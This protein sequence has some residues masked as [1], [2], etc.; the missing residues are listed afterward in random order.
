M[1]NKIL[2][3]AVV[4]IL[5]VSGV[6]IYFLTD[7]N[8]G[9]GGKLPTAGQEVTDAKGRTVIVPDNLDNGIITVGSSG[10]LRFL[11]C[12]DVYDKIIEV[13]KG[14]VTDLKHGRAYSYAF[15][16]TGFTSDQYHPDGVMESDTAEKIGRKNPS[17][18]VIQE[19]VWNKYT[20][21][22]Q[23]LADHFTTVVISDQKMDEMWTSEYK[24]APWMVDTFELLGTVLGQ[25]D[26]AQEI[27][28][29]IETILADIRSHVG[30]SVNTKT[31]VAGVT[32]QG[33]NPLTNTFPVY[34]PLTLAG[35]T[36]AY[37]KSTTDIKVALTEEDVAQLD[38]DHI[39]IDPSSS[40]KLSEN[41]SQLVMKY[42]YEVNNDSDPD[43]DIKLYVTMPLVWDNINYDCALVSAYYIAHLL[44]GTLTVEEVKSK[45]IDVF[46]LF[47]GD[48]GKNVLSDMTA[49]FE[50]KSAT[51]NVELPL[52]KEVKIVLTGSKYYTAEV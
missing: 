32:Y 47:Y 28:A 43:N 21:I 51:Y 12:F 35:G 7:G 27:I 26:R 37:T 39:L 46:T 4:A 1:N 11:S 29:G 9:G 6:G 25:V 45:A 8:G 24:L 22:C 10:P 52:F 49:F 15:D 20:A 50:N 31:Y 13:D 41:G 42:I 44:Y 30:A 34:L 36:N 17:L 18:I 33:S 48:N 23:T 40:D 19:D 2:A 16:Y 3:V 5:I 14:D 38:F